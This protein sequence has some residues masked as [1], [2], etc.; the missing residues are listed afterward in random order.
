[1]GDPVHYVEHDFIDYGYVTYWLKA[2][3][4]NHGHIC[5]QAKKSDSPL[6][7]YALDCLT[8][9][10]V[11]LLPDDKYVALS[12]VWGEAADLALSPELPSGDA[13]DSIWPPSHIPLT[14]KDSMEVTKNTGYRY[15]WVD[16]YCIPQVDESQRHEAIA[17]MHYVYA[18]AEFTIIALT[19]DTVHAGLRGVSTRT[20][21]NMQH[22]LFPNSPEV[23]RL[24]SLIETSVWATR[25]W[26]FQELRLS[27][28]CLFFTD[29]RVYFTCSEVTISKAVPDIPPLRA[30][31]RLVDP[32]YSDQAFEPWQR[33]IFLD[34]LKYT[35]KTLKYQADILDAFR[36]I[37]GLYPFIT[38]W[39]I[40]IT[41]KSW[42]LDPCIGFAMG[43][44]WK[45][46]DD[47]PDRRSGRRP[48]FPT[49]S[50][51]SVFGRIRQSVPFQTQYARFLESNTR[52]PHPCLPRVKPAIKIQIPNLGEDLAE[53]V[54]N[55]K[56]KMLPETSTSIIVEG[57]VLEVSTVLHR[58]YSFHLRNRDG[59][60]AS[61]D[62]FRA[63]IDT[64]RHL[65]PLGSNTVKILDAL[66]IVNWSD[67]QPETEVRF[68]LML[69]RWV[70]DN[71]AERVGLLSNYHK[72]W[73][74]DSVDSLSRRRVKFELR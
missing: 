16:R 42:Q 71:I 66:V 45:K 11:P 10:V 20:R 1:M 30:M 60:L 52:L 67:S 7:L 19:G 2:C 36:G 49:W 50:W 24:G 37:I 6:Q 26:T 27:R 22:L 34:R 44:L 14:I 5:N 13:S 57:D 54:K 8:K 39:G 31:A 64:D 47:T 51:T 41:C 4:L 17:N 35:R 55:T 32:G 53:T 63:S 58:P 62:S 68:V 65:V 74:K 70:G 61:D 46:D 3:A 21:S 40:P 15:L 69:L 25:G 59:T 43:L 38:L 9:A 48:G 18:G 28:R 72:V 29:Y 12:Y 56:T 23:L 33:G 73:D